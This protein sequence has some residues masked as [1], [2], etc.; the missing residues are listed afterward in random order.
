MFLRIKAK[1]NI[2]KHEQM[3]SILVFT[4]QI[5]LQRVY[6][7]CIKIINSLNVLSALGPVRFSVFVPDESL[8]STKEV[9]DGT[10]A[11]PP[12]YTRGT[13]TLL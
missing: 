1:Y 6:N 13:F 3:L 12:D 8:Q 9:Q 4:I 10:S 11:I 2:G 7:A 5:Q